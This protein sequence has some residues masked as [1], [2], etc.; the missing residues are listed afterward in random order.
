VIPGVIFLRVT[1]PAFCVVVVRSTHEDFEA[2]R[3]G[4]IHIGIKTLEPIVKGTCE[5]DNCGLESRAIGVESAGGPIDPPAIGLEDPKASQACQRAHSNRQF[6]VSR[7][8][9]PPPDDRK[10]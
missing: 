5:E 10:P 3:T 4:T 6:E 7:G 2:G 1:D 9:A 8:T